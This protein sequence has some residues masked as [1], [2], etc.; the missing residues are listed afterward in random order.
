MFL[1][2]IDSSCQRGEKWQC[3]FA[4]PLQALSISCFDHISSVESDH[5]LARHLWYLYSSFNVFSPLPS[6]PHLPHCASVSAGRICHRQLKLRVGSIAAWFQSVLDDHRQH[7]VIS[8]L[9]PPARA[10]AAQNSP[11]PMPPMPRGGLLN[12]C[13]A[14]TMYSAR[15]MR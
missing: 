8:G 9:T 14:L 15:T 4:P 13:F 12:R 5:K 7:S 6:P 2:G 1:A 3:G 11:R 10:A